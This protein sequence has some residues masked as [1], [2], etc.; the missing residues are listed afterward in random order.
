[1]KSTCP[2]TL[3]TKTLSPLYCMNGTCYSFLIINLFA[4]NCNA[5]KIGPCTGE[6]ARL[7]TDSP[8]YCSID[9][10]NAYVTATGLPIFDKK[11]LL[12]K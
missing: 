11:L 5:T 6:L 7:R 1:M 8:L 2:I 3:F 4:G 12:I 9:I 10:D